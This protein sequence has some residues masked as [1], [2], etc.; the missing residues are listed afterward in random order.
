MD[1]RQSGT[2]TWLAPRLGR[3]AG[4]KSENSAAHG[5]RKLSNSAMDPERRKLLHRWNL[6]R[7]YLR[8]QPSHSLEVSEEVQEA[9]RSEDPELSWESASKAWKRWE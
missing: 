9:E 1:E 6:H 4:H 7:W 5:R 8:L 2:R 3:C